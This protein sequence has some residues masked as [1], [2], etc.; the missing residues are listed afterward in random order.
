M[1]TPISSCST[2]LKATKS[3]SSK[4]MSSDN[5]SAADSYIDDLDIGEGWVFD[6]KVSYSELEYDQPFRNRAK[7]P[8]SKANSL[9][10]YDR[11]SNHSADIFS[12]CINIFDHQNVRSHEDDGN[13]DDCDFDMPNSK[14]CYLGENQKPIID[15]ACDANGTKDSSYN[16]NSI[17]SSEIKNENHGCICS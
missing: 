17:E 13:D 16:Q 6:S 7:R 15:E 1:I 12:S 10:D 3:F 2:L 4:A 14:L 5:V 9:N 8:N 11:R